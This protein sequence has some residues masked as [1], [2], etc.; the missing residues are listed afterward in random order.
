MSGRFKFIIEGNAWPPPSW[1]ERFFLDQPISAGRDWVY[2]QLKTNDMTYKQVYKVPSPEGAVQ[3][4]DWDL[5]LKF[6]QEQG[7]GPGRILTEFYNEAGQLVEP[8]PNL[9]PDFRVNVDEHALD[10]ARYAQGGAPPKTMD[11]APIYGPAPGDPIDVFA[12]KGQAIKQAQDAIA[13]ALRISKASAPSEF[14]Q[15]PE[16]TPQDLGAP[17]P[18][19]YS[20]FCRQPSADIDATGLEIRQETR[21]AKDLRKIAEAADDFVS[22]IGL[23]DFIRSAFEAGAYRLELIV[24]DVSIKVYKHPNN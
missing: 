22:G 20:L 19:P 4:E 17:S 3:F 11:W 10:A 12:L 1:V 21:S 15:P 14:V 5:A 2:N 23:G 18:V 8:P 16:V 24:G 13:A 6:A 7:L 9:P